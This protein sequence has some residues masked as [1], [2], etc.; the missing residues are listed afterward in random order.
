MPESAV[1]HI[2]YDRSIQIHLPDHAILYYIVN[3]KKFDIVS[4]YKILDGFIK[5]EVKYKK[6]LIISICVGNILIYLSM[7]LR[8]VG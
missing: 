1:D 4:I 3:C 6:A 2:R 7:G 8:C 5:G